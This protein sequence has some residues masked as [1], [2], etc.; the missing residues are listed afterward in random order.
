MTL[1]GKMTGVDLIKD[2]AIIFPNAFLH[3]IAPL[4]IGI[5]PEIG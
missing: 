4:E 1:R 5:L 2:K 3:F